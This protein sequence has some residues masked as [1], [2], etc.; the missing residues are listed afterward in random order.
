[1]TAEEAAILAMARTSEITDQYP[2][3]RSLMYRRLGLRQ[4]ELMGMAARRN[5]DYYGVC[6]VSTLD[7]L[8]ATDLND[9]I[10]PVPT[11]ELLQ[12]VTV[13]DAGTSQWAS[14]TVINI[15]PRDQRDAELPPRATLRDLVLQG[16]DD[17][18]A[19]VVSVEIFYS[20]LSAE[21]GPFDKDSVLELQHPHNE[22][23]II[24]LTRHLIRKATRLPANIRADVIQQLDAEEKPLLDAYLA[25]VDAYVPQTSRFTRPSNR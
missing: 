20:R 25:H 16:V 19:N 18:L 3:T 14:G 10:E 2:A 9:I 13:A 23:L 24:D 15:V 11:P 4:R 5:P 12:E 1:M 22:L 6:A 17:D 21:F 7:A 8:T